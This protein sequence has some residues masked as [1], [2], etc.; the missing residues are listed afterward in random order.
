MAMGDQPSATA[1]P[2]YRPYGVTPMCPVENMTWRRCRDVLHPYALELPT[3]AQWEYACRAGTDSIWSTGSTE[4]SLSGA[5]NLADI[6]A[7]DARVQ[8]QNFADVILEDGFV[9]TAPVG[10]FAPNAFGL[11][12]MHG[13]VYERCLEPYGPYE[14]SRFSGDNAY[15]STR[16]RDG[17]IDYVQRGGAYRYRAAFA[18][19]AHRWYTSE[20][21]TNPDVGV[22]PVRVL[23]R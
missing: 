1:R 11:H 16:A 7:R 17:A 4:D 23:E 3:E 8:W 10:S 22:R 15:R 19:S 12:D 5:A 2:E 21:A 13:N 6:T 9:F 14:P 18:A 20:Q